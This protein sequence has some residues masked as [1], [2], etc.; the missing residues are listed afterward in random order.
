[1][2]GLR[3]GGVLSILLGHMKNVILLVSGAVALAVGATFAAEESAGNREPRTPLVA[4]RHTTRST[5]AFVEGDLFDRLCDIHRRHPGSCDEVWLCWSD[6][7]D[8]GRAAECGRRMAGLRSRAER[9]GVLLSFQQG[10]TL[11]HEPCKPGT[12]DEEDLQMDRDGRRIGFS[13][14]RSPRV[15]ARQRAAAKAIIETLKPASYW[16]DDDLRLGVYRPDGCF[17]P[18]CLAA[19]NAQHGL[20]LSRAELVARLYGKTL[21][22]PLRALWSRFNAESIACYAEATRL[23]AEDAG[24]GTVL[25]YQAIWSDTIYPGRDFRPVLEALSGPSRRRTGIRPGAACYTDADPREMVVKCLSVAREAERCKGYGLPMTVCYEQD[26]FMRQAINKSPGAVVTES[27]LALASGADSLSE[28]CY[29]RSTDEPLDYH[30]RFAAALSRARPYFE[31]LS[32]SSRRTSL[33]GVARF[34]GSGAAELP[35]WDLRSDDERT[36]AFLGV[37]VTVEESSASNK[38]WF[39]NRR[40]EEALTAADRE[41]LAHEP[42]AKLSVTASP[43]H[44]ERQ[45]WLN[46]LDR[47]SGGAFPV[48][49]DRALRLRVLPRIDKSGRTE[50]VTLLNCSVGET[51]PFALRVRNPAEARFELQGPSRDPAWLQAERGDGEWIVRVPTIGPWEIVTV[52]SETS[53]R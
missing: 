31:R 37:P 30:E 28:Y 3:D 23:G 1:M 45:R 36:L 43:T 18:R 13:C 50:S 16:L 2:R 14:P 8:P 44:A 19:F 48:R 51:E 21:R 35:Q 52:F 39:L 15:C 41:R 25:G 24:V 9:E 7:P 5:K 40:S 46:E 4:V 29:D 42:V 11:G 53:R 17:C 34:L 27:A 12:W 38:V 49:I 20:S 33:G 26:N 47:A 10:V 6:E 32:A 22:E